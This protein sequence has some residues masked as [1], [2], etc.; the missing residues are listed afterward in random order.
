[1]ATQFHIPPGAADDLPAV[2][3][4]WLVAIHGRVL[5]D[6]QAQATN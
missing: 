3:L 4:D 2:R 5:A 6:Q 1:L